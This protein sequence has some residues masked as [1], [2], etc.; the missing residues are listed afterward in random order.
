MI[1]VNLLDLAYKWCQA[2]DKKGDFVIS[3]RA[4]LLTKFLQSFTKMLH[5][6][7]MINLINLTVKFYLVDVTLFH[8]RCLSDLCSLSVVHTSP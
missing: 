8:S 7:C 4:M 3:H 1:F 2:T 6:Q 5:L